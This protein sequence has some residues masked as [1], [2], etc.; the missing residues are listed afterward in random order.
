[1]SS[2]LETAQQFVYT[3]EGLVFG[4]LKVNVSIAFHD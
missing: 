1:M 4:D 3:S 2:E